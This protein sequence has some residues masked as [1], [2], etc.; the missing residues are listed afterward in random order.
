MTLRVAIIGG[1]PAGIYAADLLTKSGTDVSV[2]V[3][4]RL[5]AP[6]G[7]VRY[8]V[9]PDHPRIK[10]IVKALQRVLS[11]PEVRFLGNVTYGV[12]C[13]L[14]DLRAFYDA[15]VIATGA[16]SDRDLG[17]PGEELPGSYGA[18]DFVSWYD[19]HPDVPRDWPLEARHVAVVG[20]GNVALDVARV[21]AKTGEEMLATDVP[22]NVHAGL[23]AKQAT[24]VHVFARRGPAYAKFSPLE[25]RELAHSP[26]VDVVVHAEGF[27]VDDASME[28]I[29][30]NKQAKMV[31]NT[32][33][34]WVGRDPGDKP[35]RIHLHFLEQPVEILGEESV[36]GFRTERTRLVGDGG[37]EGTGEF[38]DWDVQAVYRAVG[39]RSTQV[40][41][42]PFDTRAA[43]IPND[44][45]RVLDLDGD[46]IPGTYV[47]GWIKRGPVGLIGH[48]KSDAAQTVGHLV[49]ETT[50]TAPERD[51]A[52]VNAYFAERGVD[53]V[54][55]ENW[56][57]LDAHEIALG[58]AEGRTRVKVVEREEMLRRAR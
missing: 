47:T 48:T 37:V 38:T 5:P 46:P 21:L 4:E 33:S 12:D 31:L 20:A 2:D 3:L 43:V 34:N 8:G 15:V 51:P 6:F 53:V 10:E 13:K 44:E 56:E 52:A 23:V 35:H 25:L 1:G 45:G 29:A 28:H 39:Y 50:A 26:N 58:E 55:F 7:L 49:E 57:R 22:A 41:D 11:K 42:L 9:A 18:A 19:G 40:A 17:I 30:A 27:E 36:T 24:D 16:M 32:L 14:D 54:E